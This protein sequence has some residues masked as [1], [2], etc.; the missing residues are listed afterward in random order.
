MSWGATLKVVPGEGL[1]L[2]NRSGVNTDEHELQYEVALM[3]VSGILNTGALGGPTHRY[4]VNITGHGN[5][6]NVPAP[7][8]ANDF[9]NIQ[10]TQETKNEDE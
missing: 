1:K 4:N 9:L 10:I 8:W 5:P 6:G 7:G 3:A 2:V